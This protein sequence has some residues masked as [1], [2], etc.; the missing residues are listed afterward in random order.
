MSR[1]AAIAQ[2]LQQTAQMREQLGVQKRELE[3]AA[4]AGVIAILTVSVQET[5]AV[6]TDKLRAWVEPAETCSGAS[7]FDMVCVD[8]NC[9]VL[10]SM[11]LEEGAM[12][13]NVQLVL[14]WLFVAIVRTV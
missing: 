10:A 12:F 2:Q 1:L 4:E 8:P 14:L 11:L 7:S 6:P 3:E 5:D 9:S 13:L